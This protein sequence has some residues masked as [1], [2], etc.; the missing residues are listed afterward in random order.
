[1]AALCKDLVNAAKRVFHT[2]IARRDAK[3]HVALDNRYIKFVKQCDKVRI[4][5]FVE[6]YKSGVH[7]LIT[8]LS[9]DDSAGVTSQPWL[10]L[11]QNNMVGFRQKM[12]S[13]HSRYSTTDDRDAFCGRPAVF[14]WHSVL[15]RLL[16]HPYT[17]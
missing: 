17:A 13:A 14:E 6:D 5:R 7:R 16:V 8:T 12:R 11:E 15:L 9:G 3:A 1:M 10:G 2:A 4:V